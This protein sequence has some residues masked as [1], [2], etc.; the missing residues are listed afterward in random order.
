MTIGIHHVQISIA[1]E[2]LERSRIFYVDLLGMPQIHDPFGI[3]GFWLAAGDQQVHLHVEAK[4]DRHRTNAHPAFLVDD[5]AALRKRL[6]HEGYTIHDQP[7]LE[8]FD[9]FHVIDP[10]GNRVELMQR[11]V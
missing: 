6:D 1:P 4:I 8:G 11:E 9:R 10:S 2:Q 3:Q 7:K 5:L